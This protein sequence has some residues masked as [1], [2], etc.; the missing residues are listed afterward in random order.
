MRYQYD[1]SIK[2]AVSE[3]RKEF[4]GFT[5]LFDLLTNFECGPK[6]C[7]IIPKRFVN[8]KSLLPQHLSILFPILQN[9]PF[10]LP[11]QTMRLPILPIGTS[12]VAIILYATTAA[13]SITTFFDDSLEF[14]LIAPTLGIAHPTGY[15]LYVLSGA[16]WSRILFPFGN[17]A[18]RM[19]MFSA[20]T[21]GIA[22]GLVAQLARELL[23]SGRFDGEKRRSPGGPRLK[24][25]SA[26]AAASAFGLGTV[27][28]GQAT[29]AEVYALHGLFVGAILLLTVRAARAQEIQP[30]RIS[31]L[32]LLLGLA[33]AHHRTTVLLLPGLFLYLAASV[34]AV[35]RPHRR[36]C[37]WIVAF[38]T[39]LLLY[40]Y[41]PLRASQ[42]M[43]DLHGSYDHS[44]SG[45]F[46]HVGASAYLFFG[47]W[48]E[49]VFAILLHQY[50]W[51]GILFA[52]LGI[53]I[54]IAAPAQS[55]GKGRRLR[56]R[57]RNFRRPS[58]WL[59]MLLV[60]VTNLLFCLF[61]RVSDVEVFL[62][63]TFLTMVL[64]MVGGINSVAN[65]W[66]RHSSL[67]QVLCAGLLVFIGV[68]PLVY[69]GTVNRSR[70]WR[71]HD[72]ATEM[73]K[74]DYAPQSRV[75]GLEG[76]A[77]ALL[78]MQQAEDLAQ[79][80]TPLWAN[81]EA[82]RRALVE[83]LLVRDV[84]VYLTRELPGTE[85]RYSFSGEGPLI[86]VWSRGTVEAGVPDRQMDLRL[87]DGTL[88]LNGVDVDLLQEAGG[89]TWRIKFYWE[90]Q[91]ALTQRIKLSLRLIHQTTEKLI[92]GP[93][94]KPI[95]VDNFPLRQTSYS[96]NWLPGEQIGDVHYIRFWEATKGSLSTVPQAL[97]V[98]LYD[99]ES[100][101]ELDRF[102]INL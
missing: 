78:Y 40:L 37:L 53:G 86:R 98:I 21:G 41:I 92:A 102:T 23:L 63:P 10:Q 32:C 19:N 13:P 79:H 73:A 50:G 67:G 27:W 45:F 47:G 70:D 49:R 91:I 58:A 62:I 52:A 12:F 3:E 5:R 68:T 11:F 97:L 26:A 18:W 31:A 64:F 54:L 96:D 93:D 17:W 28:W 6:I 7:T 60:L 77:T 81:D 2:F 84:P 90:P 72:L 61:Y 94:G 57:I 87:M 42:G 44:V 51:W 80:A 101:E 9:P 65:M 100:I 95:I 35:L 83:E 8:A 66:F 30:A 55:N 33:F 38:A 16:L 85:D 4:T 36:W 15:P 1:G 99:A 25:L 20:A 24:N 74:V 88:R 22:V 56:Y 34:P 71:A 43:R 39:P 46:E 76:E 59:F 82:A 29:V 69:N 14:Q 75:I 48:N 89:L